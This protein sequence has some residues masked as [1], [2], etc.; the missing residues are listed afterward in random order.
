M[1]N[2]KMAEKTPYLQKQHVVSFLSSLQAEE[3]SSCSQNLG[4]IRRTDD[5]GR[6]NLESVTEKRLSELRLAVIAQ[7]E[8]RS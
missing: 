1:S 5:L 7:S 3:A 8:D 2:A 4:R 6:P